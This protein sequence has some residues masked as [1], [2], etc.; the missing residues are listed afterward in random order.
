VAADADETRMGQAF[1]HRRGELTT[2]NLGRPQAPNG[3]SELP[4][5]RSGFQ[6]MYA[7]KG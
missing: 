6:L 7:E 2:E 3:P 4:G 5:G 1:I